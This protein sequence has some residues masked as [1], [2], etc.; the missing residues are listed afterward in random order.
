M[1]AR[2]PDRLIAGP[3][4]RAQ[5]SGTPAPDLPDPAP[6][7]ARRLIS[8]ADDQKLR[9]Y[10]NRVTVQLKQARA[11]LH[12]LDEPIA[13]VGMACRYPGDVQS[14]DD[15]WRLVDEGRDAVTGFPANRG[16][17]LDALY[18]PDPATTGTSYVRESG[19]VHDADEFDAE[20][21]GISPR[22]AQ[23]MDPQQRLLLESAWE[24]LENAGIR[25][26]PL[27]GSA[28]GVFV[29]IMAQEYGPSLLNPSLDAVDGYLVTGN[30]LSV[31]SGRISYT[32]G[33]EGPAMT[34]DTACSSSLVCV[35]LAAQ[36]LR[37]RE[38]DLALA[39]G[40]AVLST[41]GFFI[42]FSRQRGLAAD[43]RCKAFAASADGTSWSEGVGMLALMRLSDAERRGHRVLAV[44]RGSAVNQDGA[45]SQLS[46]P[47]GPSQQ[48]V[49]RHALADARLTPADVDAVEAHGTG[50]PLGDP[51]EAHALLSTYGQD[52]PADQPPLYLGSLKS[53]I[54]HTQAA[55]GVG[56]IIKSVMAM[57]HG[58]LPRTLHVDA[59][60][61]HVDWAEGAVDLLTEARPWPETDRPRRAAVSSFGISGT[62]AHI[63]LEQAPPAAADDQETEPGDS[64]VAAG[65]ADDTDVTAPSSLWVLSG[66]TEQAVR[67][68]A[69]RLLA[70]VTGALAA[71]PALRPADI[72]F[73]LADTRTHFDRR[74]AVAGGHEELLSGLAALAEGRRD[75]GRVPAS[76]PRPVFVF[77][78]Q[79]SQWVGMATELAATSSVFAES[80]DACE[81]ALAPFVDWSLT[82]AL[83][84]PELLERVDVVQPVLFAVMVSLARLWEFHGVVPAAVVGHSQGEIAAAVVAGALSLDDGA[85]V[86]TLRSKAIGELLSGHGAMMSIAASASR[87]AELIAQTGEAAGTTEGRDPT[88]RVGVAV[89]NGPASVVLAGEPHALTLIA[90]TCADQGIRHRLLPVDYASHSPQVATIEERLLT[91]LKTITPRPS[92]T[93]FYS[94]VTGTLLDTTELDAAYWYR[95]LRQT[96]LFHDT[97]RT[98]ADSG[99]RVFI[100]ISPHPVLTS[101]IQDTLAEHAPDA[102]AFGTLRRHNGGLGRFLAA[103]G[104]SYTHGLTPDWSTVFGDRP[105][106]VDLPTYAFQRR[107]HW[108]DPVASADPTQLGLAVT[109]HPLLG[110]V[111]HAAD[112]DTVLFTGRVSLTADS[113]L[114]DHQVFGTVLVPGAALVEL[115]VHAGDHVGASVL[116]ELVIEAP[117]VLTPDRP[118]RL[119]VSVGAESDGTRTI[120][121]HSQ[122]D[123]DPAEWTLHATGTLGMGTSTSTSTG[124]GTGTGTGT[125]TG[126]GTGTGAATGAGSHEPFVWPPE[127]ASELDPAAMYDTLADLGLTYGPLF[128]GVRAAWRA[129]D[130]LYAEVVLGEE[131]TTGFGI[132]PALV[133]AALHTYAHEAFSDGA[134]RLP[135]AWSG[136]R[137]HATGATTLRVRL[138]PTGDNTVNLHATDPT[139]QPVLT[140][141]ALTTRPIAPDQ[142]ATAARAPGQETLYEESWTATTLTAAETATLFAADDVL[143]G[144]EPG[145]GVV[146]LDVPATPGEPLSA[147]R[148]AVHRVLDVLRR[149][150]TEELCAESTLAVVTHGHLDADPAA[151]AVWGLVRSAQSEHPGRIVLVDAVSEAGPP[152]NLTT[153]V[154]AALALGE[155]QLALRSDEVLVPRLARFAPPGDPTPAPASEPTSDPTRWRADG[156]VLVTGGTGTL[157]TL[158][159]RHLVTVHGVRHLLLTSR[160]GIAAAGAPELVA[161]LEELGASV[162]V[163][164]CDV[165]DRDAVAALLASIPT[166]H[167]L[168]AVVHTAGVLDDGLVTSLTEAMTEAVLRPKADAAWHLHELTRDLDL[169]AFVLY[170]SLSGLI[171]GPGQANYAAAN[172][173]LDALARHR[174]EL[175]LPAVSLAWGLWADAS[176]MTGQ[177]SDLD[178]RRLTRTGLAPIDGKAGMAAFDAA[179]ALGRP[180][181]AITPLDREALRAADPV[182]ALFR[183]LVRSTRRRATGGASDA[184]PLADRLL[185]RPPAE[186]RE[187]LLTV[188]REQVAHVLGHTDAAAVPIG[189]AFRDLG[190]D[191]LTSVELRNRLTKATGTRLPAT[192]V[193]DHPTPEA[194]ALFLG[195]RLGLGETRTIEAAPATATDEPLAIVGMACRFPGDVRTPEELWQLLESGTEALSDLPGDRGWDLGRLR[196]DPA[197][198]EAVAIFRGGFLHDAAEFDPS[199]FGI[200]PREATV[201]DPQQRL[202]LETVW[203][204]ME[205]AG[206]DPA[207]LRGS[208]TGVFAGSM[209]RDY[210]ARFTGSPDGYDEVLGTSNAGGVVSGRISYT[211]GFEGP[212]VTLDTA[213]SS[214]LVAMHMAG[215]SLRSGE[216]DLALA[217]GVTVMST[218]ETLQEFSRQRGLSADGRCKAF[219]AGADGTILSEGVGVLLLERLSDAQRNGHRVLA[220]LR[221]SAVN[222]DGASNGLTAPN[223]PAQ[224]R[225]IRRAL[226]NAGLTAAD[227][228]VVEAHGTGTTLGDPIEAQALLATYGQDRPEDQ[229]VLVG[230]LK[231]NIGHTQAAAGVGGVI[232]MVEA[233]RRGVVP[234]TLHVDEPSPHV[235]WDSGAVE[236]LTE[237][238]TWPDTGRLR[239][240][241]VSSFGISG[242]NAHV[243]VE[244]APE[245]D[246]PTPAPSG[247]VVPWVLSGR[248]DEAVR[249]QAARL[250]EWV[251][252]SP[253]LDLAGAGLTLATA[254]SRF[255]RGAVAVGADREELLSALA[256]ITDGHTPLVGPAGSGVAMLFAGQGGQRFGM[257]QELYATYPVFA[258]AVDDAL[259]AIDKELTGHVDHPVRDVL[260]GD[261]NPDLLNQ[262][263]YTQTTLFAIEIGLYRLLESWGTR[264]DWL[265]GHSIGEIAAAHIAG[266]FSL[267]D[268]ARLVAARG[269]LMQ[270]L[271]EGGVMAAIEAAEA[272]VI[273]LLDDA[274]G[275]AAVNGPTSVVISGTHTAAE[276]VT[277][278]F[279]NTGH[280]VKRLTVSHA[281][282]S[283]LM[284]PMLD[285]FAGIVEGLTFHEPSIPIV[286]TVTGLPVES[287]TLTDP[288]YW[289]RHVRNTVRFHDAIAHLADQ[290]IGGYIEI[291][292]SGVLVAQT[293]QILDAT[294]HEGPLVLPTLRAGQPEAHTTLTAL[295]QLHLAGTGTTPD[296]Q[297]VFANR[298]T[299]TDLPTYPFQRQRYW[300]NAPTPGDRSGSGTGHPLLASVVD[301][302]D[303]GSLVLSGRLSTATHP[304][305]TDHLVLGSVVVPGSAWIEVALYAAGQS[306]ATTLQELVIERPLVINEDESVRLQVHIGT[307]DAGVRSISIHSRPDDEDTTWTRHATGVLGTEPPPPADTFTQWPPAGATAQDPDQLYTALAESG[308]LYGPVFQGVEAFWRRGDELFAEVALPE[309]AEADGFGIHPALLDAALHP[310]AHDVL[311]DGGVQLPFAWS[312]VRLDTAGATRLRVRLAPAGD[313]GVSLQAADITGA[314]VL[315]VESVTA[316]PVAVEQL[317]APGGQSEGALLELTWSAL[318]VPTTAASVVVTPL[319]DALVSTEPLDGVVV[320]DAGDVSH[321]GDDEEASGS[322]APADVPTVVRA[323]TAQ[324]LD[325]LR[326]WLAAPH[327]EGTRLV[328]R[329]TGAVA[330]EPA[331]SPDLVTATVWGLVRS[332]Q[333]EH[334]GRIVLLDG[335]KGTETDLASVLSSDEHQVAVRGGRLL[336]PRLVPLPVPVPDGAAPWTTEG[337]VLIT[338]GTGSLGAATARHLV[339]HHGIRHLLLTS[340]RGPHAEG[341]TELHTELTRAGAHITITA[342]DT[343]DPSQL[344]DLLT[345]IPTH[346]PLTAIIHTA[347]TLDD[348]VITTMTPTQLHDVLRPK[349]DA[350]WNLH[351]QTQHLN[352]TAFVLYSSVAGVLGTPGQANYAAANSF[353]DALAQHR[354]THHQPATSIAWG[355]WA[356]TSGM[357]RHLSDTDRSRLTRNGLGPIST[358]VGTALL[359]AARATGRPAVAASAVLGVARGEVPVVLRDLVRTA[360]RR[361]TAVPDA[362]GSFA[363][364]LRPLTGAQRTAFL[365]GH[366]R[367]QV[368]QVLGHDDPAAIG[369][370]QPFQDLGFDSLTAVELRNRLSEVAGERLPATVVFD[371]PTP[372][373]LATFLLDRLVPHPH[374]AARAKVDELDVFLAELALADEDRSQIT[375]HLERLIDRWRDRAPDTPGDPEA[376]LD[377]ASDE[378]LFR[379][380][381]TS[382][383]E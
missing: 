115:A 284:E 261:T 89:V 183:G 162:T 51:I 234:K 233:L 60:T 332:A 111:V 312:G 321:T 215:Q 31:A 231:S 28:T 333:S 33:F 236:L 195:A 202:L 70:H 47:N 213:C 379:L 43:G 49:I 130:A 351:H 46:A 182:P 381:D 98:I 156:T 200:S 314:P 345:T 317:S 138:T 133:D 65:V 57:R 176:A 48:R 329:T 85:R 81:R 265:V 92:T 235:E 97:T 9:D 199:F 201:V 148:T 342:C 42:D 223:G 253:E 194:L 95:N 12:E 141:D 27:R 167:P 274:V 152:T 211:F 149:W 255:E 169:S 123:Q 368:A 212:A 172:S 248:T 244:Q 343:T 78:G 41:P 378:E 229:P 158:A 90:A 113:W 348:S 18:D 350:A 252:K 185:R 58:V 171:G 232:K 197:S 247:A 377:S 175:G 116:D 39:G 308:L 338:G 326:R 311:A 105:R 190:F 298:T 297:T 165:G 278:H 272:D 72:G 285:D 38:C 225:V 118:R 257:G 96:V 14:P 307:D 264:P 53:N 277:T 23:A 328:V 34:V 102:A 238:R 282:H 383:K 75:V 88:E 324:V 108:L 63:I 44:I 139:G 331:E 62:N 76:D 280:R 218:P 145:D 352:L 122:A 6:H 7:L 59:P 356:D 276:R 266:V 166:E 292:P 91:D 337:T 279:E 304:W 296:W 363:E 269:R 293:Q 346:T 294:G 320:L 142:L 366:V 289:V 126:T 17:D 68:Q 192:L 315:T 178:H 344:A 376:D 380:V 239:R 275:I 15:L 371:H 69:A 19:F 365:I 198:P 151:S 370:D 313:D 226:A 20:F 322:G 170:S 82:D 362:G 24:V 372:H 335:E 168:T 374:V 263:V 286:S 188:V 359:D 22:E 327:L 251:G 109:G 146:V 219:A 291:G 174:T 301:V 281:F 119:Q 224:E 117:L 8:V 35:H 355:L 11:R 364:R 140:I 99:S 36:A 101:G 354:T 104:E 164:A 318:S 309:A 93:P 80:L 56:G 181:V 259:T 128:Q 160:R 341:A 302:A 382:R 220:V 107:R 287:D 216:C 84:D 157:A 206:I 184:G 227:I 375:T 74:A 316:R 55:A 66:G 2:S 125:S 205:R 147:T 5:R 112:S 210:S 135:F 271:P 40:V 134:V 228:D 339:H 3:R 50:T 120:A 310:R 16:W 319:A 214:S 367:D 245:V 94:T 221:G 103:V 209:H 230:S 67:D 121:V 217:G 179:L 336:R 86:V 4:D 243:I 52:R 250:T 207:S 124:T 300:L 100:E 303:S 159:A 270:A 153:L 189:Q 61:P 71:D 325:L 54:G 30:Q 37:N 10:L 288:G 334:P 186:Q 256:E 173:F 340:R 353:L 154:P 283:P 358:A 241:G 106:R 161:E 222:Q 203:E 144:A 191:S 208:N 45:S 180:V 110:A 295:G 187:A 79:G 347:G 26:G 87:A 361:E 13:I 1:T 64:P 150:L 177:L 290:H 360:R 349:V 249:E 237:N 136:V 131:A 73:S 268:A 196:D 369:Q 25:P 246:L 77:P 273:P 242:T 21:F 260:L 299:L 129:G 155:P 330:V 254:R 262:T 373:A 357:T 127:R 143:N 305:L 306:G 267:E 137:L 163:A 29:G 132:H 204:A 83:S 240:A 323:A 114:D 258:T 32:F 193:F